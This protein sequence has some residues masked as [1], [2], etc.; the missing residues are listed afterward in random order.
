MACRYL[1]KH[2]LSQLSLKSPSL[3]QSPNAN[4][5]LYFAPS[6]ALNGAAD[7]ASDPQEA[8]RLADDFGTVVT[9]FVNLAGHAESFPSNNGSTPKAVKS[10]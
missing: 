7:V 9:R 1:L 8:D 6:H 10:A 5:V 2:R 4:Y 3:G